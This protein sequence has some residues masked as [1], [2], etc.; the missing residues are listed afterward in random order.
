MPPEP[1]RVGPIGR[2]DGSPVRRALVFAGFMLALSLLARF[3]TS[4][5]LFVD[6]ATTKRLSM[7][8]LGIFLVITGN[9]IPKML[10]PLAD[11]RCHAAKVQA[12]QRFSGWMW[13]LTGLAFS[14]IWLLLPLDAAYP[15]SMMVLLGGMLINAVRLVQLWRTRQKPA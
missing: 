11:L 14:A 13:V 6:I 8:M 5:G 12:F 7:A 3:A 1:D 9:G 10:S 2:P 15:L 4:V